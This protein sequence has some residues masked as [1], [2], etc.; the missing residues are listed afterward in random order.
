VSRLKGN[1]FA[2]SVGAR[3]V[4]TVGMLVLAVMGV[5]FVGV[6]G[7]GEVHRGSA[8]LAGAQ[9]RTVQDTA[10]LVAASFAIHETALLQ[11]AS[12][13]HETDA[14]VNQE[15]DSKLVPSFEKAVN[16]LRLDYDGHP[17]DLVRVEAIHDGL[18]PYLRLRE[19]W[20]TGQR[21]TLTAAERTRLAGQVD[22]IMEGLVLHV[23][24]CGL[25]RQPRPR[26]PVVGWTGP[27]GPPCGSW[28]SGW[29]SS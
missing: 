29:L 12:D 21:R 9:L 23:R 17:T 8:Q 19:Q 4:V 27:T 25:T 18:Q 26:A 28:V 2:L 3:F 16:A 11:I 10:D 20:F 22:E 7:V 5:A 1:R 13:S 24:P 15:L 14:M 6:L